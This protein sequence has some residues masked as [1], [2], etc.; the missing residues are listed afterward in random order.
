VQL[1]AGKRTVAKQHL[2]RTCK[3]HFRPR[4]D[5]RVRFRAGIAADATYAAATTDKLRIRVRRAAAGRA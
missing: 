5:R 1:R 3:A 4:I 2:S